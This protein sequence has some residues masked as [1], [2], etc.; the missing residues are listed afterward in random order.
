M[1]IINCN[2]QKTNLIYLGETAPTVVCTEYSF[3]FYDLITIRREGF[4]IK[5]GSIGGLEDE[6]NQLTL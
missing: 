3:E 6:H 2:K 5:L 4:I 1:W